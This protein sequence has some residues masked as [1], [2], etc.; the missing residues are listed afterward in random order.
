MLPRV[1]LRERLV[2]RATHRW[3]LARRALPGRYLPY[4]VKGG[5]AY[6]SLANSPTQLQRLLRVYEPA[7][8]AN[9]ARYLPPGGGF[10]DVG[11]NAGDF[12]V[13][14]AHVGGPSTRVLAVE[15]EEENAHW[16]RRTVQRNGLE[17]QVTVVNAAASDVTGEV[18]LLVTA[19]S[20]TH[21]IVETELHSAIDAFRP[22]R[23][24]SIPARPLDDLVEDAGLPRV[25]VVKIDVEG[26]E[27]LV[28]RGATRLLAADHA[29]TMLIDLHFGV[30]L[31]ELGKLLQDNRFSLRLEEQPDVEIPRIPPHTL[32]I[33]AVRPAA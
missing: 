32:S 13:W 33:V 31:D 28:L 24:V 5:W 14:A 21:S 4:P 26:A 2:R 11:A 17:A 23:R 12:T 25:D 19:K 7:K 1:A 8:Y 6:L 9:I 10:V 30:D 16:L 27:M 18:E 22:V 20:G 29:L 3:S 15:A